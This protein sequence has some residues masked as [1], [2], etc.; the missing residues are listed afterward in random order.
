MLKLEK[1]PGHSLEE[2]V[3]EEQYRL[4][5]PVRRREGAALVLLLEGGFDCNN[6]WGESR[7]NIYSVI[8]WFYC[9][10]VL[11]QSY[12]QKTQE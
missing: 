12:D 11:A 6:K 3:S 10:Q 8:Q 4:E 5:T 7:P 1:L 9:N 2:T